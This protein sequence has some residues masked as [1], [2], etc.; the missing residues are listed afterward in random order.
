MLSMYRHWARAKARRSGPQAAAKGPTT[1]GCWRAGAGTGGVAGAPAV[2][3]ASA[4]RRAIQRGG[5]AEL[6]LSAA[7]R[8]R[9]QGAPFLRVT[10]PPPESTILPP[11]FPPAPWRP[12]GPNAQCRKHRAAPT[13]PAAWKA[14]RRRPEGGGPKEQGGGDGARPPVSGRQGRGAGGCVQSVGGRSQQQAAPAMAPGAGAW[15]LAAAG[16]PSRPARALGAALAHWHLCRLP[17]PSHPSA[18]LRPV[19]LPAP[20]AR[21]TP[22]PPTLRWGRPG[23]ALWSPPPRTGFAGG[24][25]GRRG[26]WRTGPAAAWGGGAAGSRAQPRAGDTGGRLLSRAHRL[27]ARGARAASPETWRTPG[28]LQRSHEARHGLVLFAHP[29]RSSPC[30]PSQRDAPSARR[31]RPQPPGARPPP[32]PK[33]PAA[34]RPP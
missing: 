5:V 21:A 11:M 7:A 19:P 32:P 22:A 14:P 12:G 9:H 2:C 34:P 17:L 15:Q 1:W 29:T 24:Q 30:H 8:S 16:P 27:P 31:L 20:S 25:R 26:R 6:Q 10:P 23:R 28:A 3:R 18:R 33:A 4:A 13:L